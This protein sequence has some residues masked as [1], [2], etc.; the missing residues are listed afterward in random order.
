[1]RVTLSVSG[2]SSASVSSSDGSVVTTDA[3]NASMTSEVHY[4]L[5]ELGRSLVNGDLVR[6]TASES[7]GG[8]GSSKATD[9]EGHTFISRWTYKAVDDFAK[10]QPPL[11]GALNLDLDDTTLDYCGVAL[12]FPSI[13]SVSE[14]TPSGFARD[15][16]FEAFRKM[17][18][19]DFASMLPRK[20]EAWSETRTHTGT[21]SLDFGSARGSGSATATVT[22]ALYPGPPPQ[23]ELV[24]VEPTDGTAYREWIPAGST[25]NSTEPGSYIGFGVRL[26]AKDGSDRVPPKARF[27]FLLKD[28]TREPGS[29][30]N[31]PPR[32]APAHRSGGTFPFDLRLRESDALEMLGEDQQ[33]AQTVEIDRQ[34]GVAIE[35]FDFGAFG[36]LK[37]I[38]Q[39][40][41]G[42][43]LE[44][45]VDGHDDQVFETVPYDSNDNQIADAWERRMQVLDRN[46]DAKWAGTLDPIYA[47]Q[48]IEGDGISLYEKYRGFYVLSNG[49]ERVYERLDPR[50]KYVFVRNPD[51]LVSQIFRHADG[52]PESYAN[53]SRCEIRYVS[54]GGWTG[55]GSFAAGKRVVNF[56]CAPERHAVDQ[57]A[58]Y[59]IVDPSPNPQQPADWMAMMNRLGAPQVDE[60]I[61]R[62]NEGETYPDTTGP[63]AF[64]DHWR[65]ARV[66]EVV[67]FASSITN[68]LVDC[69][70]HHSA[71]L[72]AGLTQAQADALIGGFIAGNLPDY[73][74]KYVIE[75]SATL[76]H[77]MGHATGLNHHDPTDSD[78][79]RADLRNCTLRYY[80][81]RE[82]A[83]DTVDR[84][85][86]SARGHE[87]STFCRAGFNCW[88]QVQ[89]NDD[90]AAPAERAAAAAAAQGPLADP[91][92]SRR[93]LQSGP[94][95]ADVDPG[96]LEL[97]AD[98]A[99]REIAAGDPLRVWVRLH[100][101]TRGVAANWADGVRLTLVRIGAAGQRETVLGP[102]AWKPFLQQAG[103]DT[104]L[105]PVPDVTL[106]REWLASAEAA[107]LAPGRYELEISWAGAG[108]APA[109]TLPA[110]GVLS[111]G[112]IGFEAVP[113][114]GPRLLALHERHLAW[115]CNAAGDDRGVLEHR[116][117]ADRL[118][119]GADDRLAFDVHF[120]A[121]ASALRQGDPYEA[122]RSLQ[123]LTQPRDGSPSHAAELALERLTNLAPRLSL[124]E[125]ADETR[126]TLLQLEGLP[127]QSYLLEGSADLRHWVPIST[128]T[129]VGSAMPVAD[130][131][132]GPGANGYYRVRWVR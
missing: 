78:F 114:I 29:C 126:P 9:S 115:A 35:C 69:V 59:V 19:F 103:F 93:A 37:V 121:A 39:T 33:S 128:N 32:S 106:I 36:K 71:S 50:R 21:S 94:P 90:P 30:V 130:R 22:V 108:L 41:D 95:P 100:G 51:R 7:V 23:W 15:A 48:A 123:G 45:H 47:G 86:L 18:E 105:I 77:E 120:L 82:F 68:Y 1:M 113:A 81:P 53:A 65:P 25:N 125:P 14:G 76:A 16:A 116:R 28:V 110:G 55:L 24:F 70:R 62:L 83:A 4:S 52:S 44:A 118:D 117:E 66:Y 40:E 54:E 26:R 10:D 49:V 104:R 67:A 34:A 80:S 92:T 63:A 46:L 107:S 84:F 8:G 102:D 73:R 112:S 57:H 72:T 101:P 75:L 56:N 124:L 89:V 60:P 31:F 97:S 127:G 20:L 64:A 98:L 6:Y 38:A 99:W 2:N 129:L 91:V 132:P 5:E 96:P 42:L 122:A 79:S 12:S 11:G 43:T 17:P 87:P 13:E 61:D 74:R 88:G 3:V 58:L 85:E 131:R 119:P 109:E 27:T 111:A